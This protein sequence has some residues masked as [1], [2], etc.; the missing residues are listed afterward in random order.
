MKKKYLAAALLGVS[1]SAVASDY[2]VVVPVPNRT[3]TA[4]NI[5]VS[6]NAFS[7]PQ[8]WVG[9]AYPGFDFNS[10]LQVRG[11]PQFSSS[12]VHWSVAGGALPAGL[13]LSTDGKLS[14][15]PSAAANSSFQLMA[16]YKSKAGEQTYSVTVSNLIVSLGSASLP[17]GVQGTPYSFDLK[18]K[19]AISGDPAY[20][21]AGVTWSI[22]SGSLP[23]GLSL[24]A[25]GVISGTPSGESAGT[26][27]TVKAAYRT[28][29]GQ[30]DYEVVVGAIVV[31]LA[32]ATMPAGVQ[33]ASYSV[34]L[35]PKLAVSGDAAYAGT[36][37]TW[38]V[39]GG[40]L[41]AGLSLSPD[42]V[43]TGVPTAENAGTPFTVQAA[44][45]SKTGQHDYQVI[46]GAITVTL[47]SATLP[48]G[49]QGTT[50]SY[51]LGQNLA[52]SGDAAYTGTGV[53]WSVSAGSLP[54]GLTLD[55]NGV[56]TGIP[57]A[58]S[59]GT[60][61]TIQA[62]YKTKTGQQ[63]YSVVVGAISVSLGAT[64]PPTGIFG[65]TYAG[66]DLKPAL[67]VTGDAAYHDGVGVTWS[68]DSGSLPTGLS[69]NASTGVISG[70]P[71][72][73]G[74][75][76]VTIKAAY[77]SK[78]ASKA[79]SFPVIAQLQQASGYRAWSDGTYAASCKE[80]RTPSNSNY[81]YQGATGDGTYRIKPGSSTV[82][83]YC[84]QTTD[85][86]GWTLVLK[87]D[88][89]GMRS[90]VMGKGTTGVCS[91]LTDTCLT[92]GTSSLYRGTAV[93]ATITDYMF[94]KSAGGVTSL[95]N[96][97]LLLK[98]AANY[99]RGPVTAPGT[100]LY[101][102]MTDTTEGWA[103]PL[104]H[105]TDPSDQNLFRFGSADTTVWSD[106]N[107]H[108]C[109]VN[110]PA[111]TGG[112]SCGTYAYEAGAQVMGPNNDDWGNHLYMGPPTFNSSTGLYTLLPWTY[113]GVAP[114]QL[115][116]GNRTI[117][118]AALEAWRWAAFVR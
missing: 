25:D 78:S 1:L 70:S 92:S 117:G 43:I 98:A 88:F 8:G 54:P 48:A 24:S 58:E 66:L 46:V 74:A 28:K 41:P 111:G 89:N 79:Y 4:G 26:P 18:P 10:V 118:K 55:K 15:T 61:F 51:S 107:W 32:G 34:D 80:Y 21:G 93:Q 60:P 87:S 103:S 99:I 35:K 63:A 38:S 105:S 7:L 20:T 23:A 56:V 113:W 116:S 62:S 64:T 2:Y 108:G 102:L 72:A 96:D 17:N 40:S 49:V 83:V 30:Q 82:D 101:D 73:L 37:V 69:L 50:Y 19:L 47:G 5:T 45:K 33:G 14:G 109:G 22:A 77:K 42:G 85:G 67:T 86:G 36:G 53:T 12:N 27:F 84:D 75:P 57:T 114:E 76:A 110:W 59:T 3:A 94:L 97:T 29:S 16:M 91:S 81:R 112:P 39:V 44:Y 11:D 104:N 71:T 13:S 68:V 6:L 65:Q 52:V 90:D 9:D 31:T 95:Y 115:F 100:Q 106:G